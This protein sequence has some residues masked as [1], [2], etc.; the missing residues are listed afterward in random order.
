METAR[1]TEGTAIY[2]QRLSDADVWVVWCFLAYVSII[3]FTVIISFHIG[4]VA[5]VGSKLTFYL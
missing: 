4:L 3:V 2:A 1:S 5:I